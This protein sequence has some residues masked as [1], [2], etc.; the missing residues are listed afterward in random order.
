MICFYEIWLF[1]HH[2]FSDCVVS[3][4]YRHIRPAE[5]VLGHLRPC[6][7]QRRLTTDYVR[8]SK[9]TLTTSIKKAASAAKT[10]LVATDDAFNADKTVENTKSLIDQNA[11]ALVG[12]RGTAMLK[13]KSP[14]VQAAGI[15]SQ[16][17]HQWCHVPGAI[18]FVPNQY[19]RQHRRRSRPPLTT[20]EPLA[21]KRSPPFT[22][23]TLARRGWRRCERV[24]TVLERS[25]NGTIDVAKAVDV[26]VPA[27]SGDVGSP[28]PNPMRRQGFHKVKGATA[29]PGSA[30][31]RVCACR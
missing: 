19:A 14:F 30:Y 28:R 16:D 7:Q 13:I 25:A 5:I 11:M 18:P 2:K 22:R 27:A 10:K 26:I 21:S 1:F 24:R 4:F 12:F 9:C 23:T 3:G 15:A 17:R 6:S 20:L 31:R 8:G 29:V